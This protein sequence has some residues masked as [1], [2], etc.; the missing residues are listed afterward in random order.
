MSRDRNAKQRTSLAIGGTIFVDES[1][2]H[3]ES[4][5]QERTSSKDG[6]LRRADGGVSERVGE[7]K[8]KVKFDSKNEEGRRERGAS[9]S[10]RRNEGEEGLSP[11]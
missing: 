8:K 3:G 10:S 6:R 1:V 11:G 7:K 2:S 5:S 9:R 4:C